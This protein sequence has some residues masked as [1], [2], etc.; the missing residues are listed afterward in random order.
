MVG[1]NYVVQMASSLQ[2]GGNWADYV[3]IPVTNRLN[4]NLIFSFHPPAGMTFIP[5]GSF[6][7][8][9]VTDNSENGDAAP[10][11]TY[12]SAFYMDINLVSYAQWQ[13]VYAWAVNK[14]YGFGHTGSGKAST[15]PVQT[16]DWYDGVKWCNARSQ[17]AGLTPVYFNDVGLT[18]V[19]TNGEVT[20]YANWSNNGYRLPTEAEWEKAARGGS[21]G[22]RFPWGNT[23]SESLANYDA[24]TNA[25]SYDLGPNGPNAAYDTGGSPFTSPVGSFPANGYGLRDMSGNT[26]EWCCDWFTNVYAG[27][28]DPRGAS[29]GTTKVIR[30]GC[31]VQNA[32]PARCDLRGV[33]P[34]TT[35]VNQYGF[36]CVRSH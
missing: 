3:Q 14:G 27:G 19:Y 15:H 26:Y 13:T 21:S 22:L 33:T 25:Y 20:P 36:R 1:T 7:M 2:A 4:T 11:N 29:T 35:A 12:V 6:M 30:G 9:D 10:T 16:I 5:A 31:W 28:N 23:I 17:M 8:G 24:Y 18:I 34:P 32:A